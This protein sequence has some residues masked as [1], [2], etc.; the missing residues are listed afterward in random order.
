M[1]INKIILQAKKCWKI[2]MRVRSLVVC[3][4]GALG[5]ARFIPPAD[6]AAEF[7]TSTDNFNN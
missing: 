2:G 7:G 5:L 6:S 4:N 1:A 3:Q